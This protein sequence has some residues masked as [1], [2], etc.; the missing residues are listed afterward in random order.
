VVLPKTVTSGV[1][2][3]LNNAASQYSVSLPLD[4]R[5]LPSYVFCWHTLQDFSHDENEIVNRIKAVAI[6]SFLFI[7]VILKN[8]Y[9]QSDVET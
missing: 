6:I 7:A 4:K 5:V 8:K 9:K 3:I 1:A 2:S